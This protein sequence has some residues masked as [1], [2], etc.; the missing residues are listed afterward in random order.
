[1]SGFE[2]NTEHH[3]SYAF[4]GI[5]LE[6]ACYGP[7][8][9]EAPTIIL[10]HEGLGCVALWRTIP[11]QLATNTGCGVFAYSRAG[12]GASDIVTLPR[13]LDY[14]TREADA[15]SRILDV[16]NINKAVLFG[17]SDGA[18]IAAIY[19]GSAQDHRVRGLVL[20]APHFFVE[21]ISISAIEQTKNEYNSGNLKEK[22]S[23]YH[24]H[25]DVA[26][27][28]WCDAWL[29]KDFQNWNIADNIDYLRIPVLAIQGADDPYGTLAQIEELEAR[30]YAPVDKVILTDCKHSP[31][32]EKQQASLSAVQSWL[33]RLWQMEGVFNL[34]RRQTWSSP[35]SIPLPGYKH[36]PGKNARP[37]DGL[38]E[39]IAHSASVVT[40]DASHQ[41]NTA[42]RYGIRL[43]NSGFFWE[44]HEVL[45]AVWNNAPP[46]SREK[47]L[48]QGV[49]QI[50]NAQ[51]KASLKQPKAAARL[52]Q[53]ATE[54]ITRAYP[55]GNNTK[56]KSGS[57]DDG[58]HKLLGLEYRQVH[59]AA[60]HCDKIEGRTKL[61]L[62]S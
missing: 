28:G 60:T 21:P 54:C 34:H 48:V 5:K 30:S 57:T 12:Y 23:T 10:L 39:S 50:A 26:F 62:I 44:T 31:H 7:S 20:L 11:Q 59:A 55:P 16:L 9:A 58:K 32:L 2:W 38:L 45:E 46:N 49:I 53:L 56:D 18:S 33:T 36:K 8:P 61:Q 24:Q 42:W 4:D 37:V 15:L 35:D 27:N 25:T 17:H 19:A 47:H 52:Q 41:S 13:P 6:T 51:L 29:D 14:M 3:S 43:F 40:S 22:L 1:V